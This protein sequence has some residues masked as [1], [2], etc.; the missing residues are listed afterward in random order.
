MRE[1]QRKSASDC[2]ACGSTAIEGEGVEIVSGSAFQRCGCT[3]CNAEWEDHYL[4]T[5]THLYEES[6]WE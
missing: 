3:A 1:I 6:D 2:P 5:A 4:L